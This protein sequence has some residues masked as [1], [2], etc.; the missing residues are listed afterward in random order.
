MKCYQTVCLI[1]AGVCLVT[2]AA[3]GA[4]GWLGCTRNNGGMACRSLQS[5][6]VAAWSL[7]ANVFQGIAFQSLKAEQ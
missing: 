1:F 5:D 6:A 2:G 4:A 3:I 7:A